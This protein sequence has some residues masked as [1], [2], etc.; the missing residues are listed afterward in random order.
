MLSLLY[1]S[2]ILSETSLLHQKHRSQQ[3]HV[4]HVCVP[5]EQLPP[6]GR[7]CLQP[8]GL[9]GCNKVPNWLAQGDRP[10]FSS[11]TGWVLD[12]GAGT[13][14]QGSPTCYCCH[15][16][17]GAGWKLRGRS[18]NHLQE[19]AADAPSDLPARGSARPLSPG[20]QLRETPSSIPG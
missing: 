20:F 16:A 1:N 9:C 12:S 5:E 13:G 7:C 8:N 3:V 10:G 2:C 15:E 17:R 19:P 6:G 18:A 14:R 11:A 4:Q